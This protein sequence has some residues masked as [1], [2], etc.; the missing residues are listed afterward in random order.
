P[1]PVRL[2]SLPSALAALTQCRLQRPPRFACLAAKLVQ[3]QRR[4]RCPLGLADGQKGIPNVAR[5]V[6]G[7]R[8]LLHSSPGRWPR[9]RG[10]CLFLYLCLCLFLCLC[11]SRAREGHRLVIIVISR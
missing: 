3:C 4:E 7:F 1:N 5:N 6:V 2:E 10:F 8:R 11:L 9:L